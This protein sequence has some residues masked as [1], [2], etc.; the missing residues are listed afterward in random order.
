MARPQQGSYSD[1][2]RDRRPG[3]CRLPRSIAGPV[4]AV[5]DIQHRGFE[6]REA[7]RGAGCLMQ[8]K[9]KKE[10]GISP[11]EDSKG[12]GAATCRGSGV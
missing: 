10:M 3:S 4:S 1:H 11:D 7:G 12:G 9:G 8:G 5:S 6:R 2:T